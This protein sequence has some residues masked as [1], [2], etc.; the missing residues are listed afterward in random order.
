MPKTYIEN[1]QNQGGTINV[2]NS[3]IN[4]PPHIIPQK[5]TPQTGLANDINFIGRK[6]ELQKIDELLNQNSM[7]LL[8]NGIGGIGKSTLASYYLNQKKDDFDYY[9]FV[10]VN[11]NIKLSLVSAFRTSLDLKSEKIDDLFV[12]VMNKLQNLEGKKLLIIDDI[13]DMDSQIDELNTLMTL[14][15]S[16]FQ[17]L[18]TSRETREYIPQYFLDI[19]SRED[20]IE[21]FLKYYP[22]NEIDKV[23]KILKYLDYHTLFIELTAKTLKQRK[24]TLNLD[25]M[26]EKFANGEFSSIK[27]N[28]IESFNLFL[29]NLFSNDKILQDKENILFLKRLSVLPSI[30][31]S[32]E[33][34]YKF[35]VCNDEERL[36]DF[37]IELV[38][39]GWL[40]ESNNKY[41]F[42]QILKEFVWDNL[43]LSFD[44]I[45]IVVDNYINI[46]K[47]RNIKIVLQNRDNIVFFESLRILFERIKSENSKIIDYFIFLGN[48]YFYSIGDYI[49]ATLLYSQAGQIAQKILPESL[50]LAEIYT[51]IGM[52]YIESDML[53]LDTKRFLDESIRIK[54]KFLLVKDTNLAF[55]YDILASYYKAIGDYQN[56]S[57]FYSKAL[58]ENKKLKEENLD[59]ASS[60]NNLAEIYRINGD[61]K[62]AEKFYLKSLEIK[63]K[64]L[65]MFHPDIAVLYNNLGLVYTGMKLYKKAKPYYLNSLKIMKKLWGEEHPHTILAYRNLAFFFETK[66][67]YQKAKKIY[68]KVLEMG[69]KVLGEF[70][71]DTA[72]TYSNLST[73]YCAMNDLKDAEMMNEK[74]LKIRKKIFGEEHPD[75]V[76]SYVNKSHIFYYKKDYK[77]A[78]ELIQIAITL[79]NKVLP[80]NHPNLISAKRDMEMFKTTLLFDRFENEYGAKRVDIDE[81]ENIFE[82]PS[83]QRDKKIPRNSPCPCKSGKKYKKCCGK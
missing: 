80:K 32:F 40:I 77:K 61:Y 23:D 7:L 9:G 50:I 42:H 13:K 35:L 30:E 27:K 2:H 66:K 3:E 49:E 29:S 12:E 72:T 10:Q 44:D 54:E 39:N 78:Y 47:N 55:S 15:N 70:H 34:L 17:I 71:S 83:I 21:L 22:T 25:K 58:N 33:D 59:T 74:A 76:T 28:R 14:K 11:E 6:E 64:K 69:I 53:D 60:Y 79:G 43:L 45:E 48:L 46:L 65:D 31:I 52:A 38:D 19:M 20:A 51:L 36:E 16:N 4:L 1:I 73:V 5:L 67:E 82:I 81:I 18:F 37:L 68:L 63:S 8:L 56:A 75:I 24:R 62:N 41:K 26:I 57:I